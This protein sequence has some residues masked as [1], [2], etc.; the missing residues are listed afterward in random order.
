MFASPLPP[1]DGQF[2]DNESALNAYQHLLNLEEQNPL[3]IR[4]LGYML[5]YAPND[6]G[7][8]AIAQDINTRATDQEVLELGKSLYD[9]FVLYFKAVDVSMPPSSP[10]SIDPFQD[11]I[12][13]L[14]STPTTYLDAK[15]NALNRDNYRCALSQTVDMRTYMKFPGLGKQLGDNPPLIMH[16]T[17]CWHILPLRLTKDIRNNL[18]E[19]T[20]FATVF[21]ILE[22]FGGISHLELKER[23]LHHWTNILT[24]EK[25]LLWY[26][27]NLCLWLEPVEGADNSYRVRKRFP[28]IRSDLPEIITFATATNL[29]LPDRRYL[30]LHAACAKVVHMSGASDAIDSFIHKMEWDGVLSE[31][32]T[33]AGFL[34]GLL[35]LQSIQTI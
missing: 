32:G 15:T 10:P 35:S 16:Y 24:V 29:P 18:A 21:E 3:W 7:R 22:R 6:N 31:D 12:S 28:R 9:Y 19:R 30:A 25:S 23:G 27:D 17:E 11:P 20:E 4:I 5:I 13:T 34:H 26:L 14:M 33:S 1:V 2:Q 8:L